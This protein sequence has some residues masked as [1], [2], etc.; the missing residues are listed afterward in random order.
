[1]TLR[2]PSDASECARSLGSALPID[3]ATS[4]VGTRL[5]RR[6][7]RVTYRCR[8]RASVRCWLLAWAAPS[9]RF[10]IHGIEAPTRPQV[11]N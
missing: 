10:V 4:A 6:D 8:R 2:P 3:Q 11:A 7:A 5:R 9:A 1:M